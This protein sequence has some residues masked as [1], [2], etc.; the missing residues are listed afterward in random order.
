MPNGGISLLP[1]EMR[2][3]EEEELRKREQAGQN[4]PEL[5]VPGKQLGSQEP[6][7][8]GIDQPDLPAER[9]PKPTPAEDMSS[10]QAPKPPSP[11]SSKPTENQEEIVPFKQRSS[12]ARPT[13]PHKKQSP[14]APKRSLRVSLIPEEKEEKTINVKRRKIG[15]MVLVVFEIIIMS[16]GMVFLQSA[17]ASKNDQIKKIDS[18]IVAVKAQLNDLQN[19]E[20]D[21]YAFEEKLNVMGELLENHVYTSRIFTFLEAHTLP[22]VWYSSFISTDKGIVTLRASA[23][24]LKSA[25]KQISHIET[26]PEV[27]QINVNNFQTNI[28]DL[29]QIVNA[30]FE[31][32]IIFNEDFLTTVE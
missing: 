18:D 12:Q 15:L 20:K 8:I 3:K 1:E 13:P 5:Y 32:Q 22:K 31:M 11:P 24:N 6:R 2:K 7:S 4:R 23:D 21:L 16:V 10:H 9:P 27:F 14:V 30:T 28:N 29:G 25:A 17:I 19:Q 26:Q